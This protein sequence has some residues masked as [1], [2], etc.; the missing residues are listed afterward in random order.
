MKIRVVSDIHLEFAPIELEPIGE[1]LIVLAG[2]ISIG[3]NGL[4]FAKD[5]A[6]RFGVPAIVLC[7]NHEFYRQSWE[8]LLRDLTEQADLTD[9]IESG[10]ATFFENSCATYQGVRFIGATLWTDMEFFGKNFI[11]ETRVQHSLADY[12]WI[13]SEITQAPITVEDTI[14]RHVE[15]LAYIGSRLEEKFDGPTVVITHHTPSALSVPERYKTDY[16]TAGFSSRLE[17][18]ILDH[19]I[20]LFIHGHTHDHYDYKL[21]ETRIVANPRGYPDE[22]TGFDPTLLVEV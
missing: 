8:G 11:V 1:D 2:D 10:R 13:V 17:D 3:T 14:A 6:R 22:D 12:R 5:L 18:F 21:G 19:E 4:Q 9:R 7:G 15:S 20:A 16:V